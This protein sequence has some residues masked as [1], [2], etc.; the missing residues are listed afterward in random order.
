MRPLLACL[1]PLWAVFLE[2]HR[3]ASEFSAGGITHADI[4]AWQSN[5]GVRLNGWE[6]DTLFQLATVMRR[7]PQ[8]PDWGD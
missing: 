1:R 6:I 2:L 5:H 3:P 4:A 8:R 7:K